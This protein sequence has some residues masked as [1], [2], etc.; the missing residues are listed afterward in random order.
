[1]A[2]D[3][4]HYRVKLIQKDINLVPLLPT[5]KMLQELGWVSTGWNNSVLGGG[6]RNNSGRPFKLC[7]TK[8]LR[9][10]ERRACVTDLMKSFH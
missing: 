8:N 6:V 3:N 2:I 1:M 9:R 4:A 10:K 7:Q 5:S